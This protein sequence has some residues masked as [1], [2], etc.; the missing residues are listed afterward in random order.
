MKKYLLSAILALI[1]STL[2]LLANPE[3]IVCGSY[4]NL[5]N[6]TGLTPGQVFVYD[7]AT[8]TKVQSFNSFDGHNVQRIAYFNNNSTWQIFYNTLENLV[9]CNT[10]GSSAHIFAYSDATGRWAPNCAALL[11]ANN[12]SW[13][14][15]AGYTNGQIILWD[16]NSEQP[17]LIFNGNQFQQ[18]AYGIMALTLFNDGGIIYV[19]A[20]SCNGTVCI[21]NLATGQQCQTFYNPNYSNSDNS[22]WFTSVAIFQDDTGFNVIAGG[23]HGY[24]CCWNIDSQ[25]LIYNVNVGNHPKRSP[26]IPG[27]VLLKDTRGQ[28]LIVPYTYSIDSIK[29]FNAQTGEVIAQLPSN[30]A[31]I[32]DM[33]PYRMGESTKL[34][35][36][37]GN[38]LGTVQ[39]WDIES[40]KLENTFTTGQ[41]NDYYA[42][43]QNICL[44]ALERSI[45]GAI[46]NGW[47]IEDASES[48][49]YFG[50][51]STFGL[52]SQSGAIPPNMTTPFLTSV[53]SN[54]QAFERKDLFAVSHDCIHGSRIPIFDLTHLESINV[55]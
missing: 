16:I 13:Q 2:N 25:E 47:V 18:N 15:L 51:L 7:P 41:L 10:D 6:K 36:G 9:I 1:S 34:V 4:A 24:I 8:G 5:S 21:Y 11:K 55:N 50:N 3:Y 32:S 45:N 27:L 54:E 23:S 31:N 29:I 33:R 49:E 43:I 48:V 35:V 46:A 38:V 52:N 17:L 37:L 53:A 22:N 19:A 28:L 39:I 44:Y 12:G 14:I 40:Q 26:I 42:P 20:A 30:I